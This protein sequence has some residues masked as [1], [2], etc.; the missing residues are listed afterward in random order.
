MGK[1][2]ILQEF[3]LVPF[4]LLLLLLQTMPVKVSK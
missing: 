4:V 2:L 3:L 1:G